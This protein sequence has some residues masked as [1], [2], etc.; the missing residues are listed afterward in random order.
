M[1]LWEGCGCELP[2]VFLLHV[3]FKVSDGS[4]IWVFRYYF[5]VLQRGCVGC[6]YCGLVGGEWF[7]GVKFG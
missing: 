5:G 1:G 3:C 2:L 6:V 4:V 7:V